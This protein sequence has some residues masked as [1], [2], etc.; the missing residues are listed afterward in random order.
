MTY[1][2]KCANI[3][4]PPPAVANPF[5]VLEAV[6][7]YAT[8]TLQDPADTILTDPNSLIKG[9]LLLREF[10]GSGKLEIGGTIMNL[11]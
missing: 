6:A 4:T 10:E 3:P 1:D 5:P 11:P 2:S 8:C 9:T 7:R